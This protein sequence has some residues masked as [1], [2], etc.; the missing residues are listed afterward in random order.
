MPPILR[1]LADADLDLGPFG[2]LG[3]TP[4]QCEEDAIGAALGRQLARVAR[5]PHGGAIEADEVRLA[6]H[7]AAAQLRDPAVRQELIEDWSNVRARRTQSQATTALRAN[8][9]PPAAPARPPTPA[10]G[11]VPLSAFEHTALWVIAHSGGWNAESKR[12]LWALAHASSIAPVELPGIIARVAQRAAG[13]YSPRGSAGD[14]QSSRPARAKT[15]R[16]LPR[17]IPLPK[18]ESPLRK[19]GPLI[20]VGVLTLSSII[21]VRVIAVLR[22]RELSARTIA[23]ESLAIPPTATPPLPAPIPETPPEDTLATS[24]PAPWPSLPTPLPPPPSQ[25]RAAPE[26]APV[27]TV[28]ELPPVAPAELAPWLQLA[29]RVLSSTAMRPS[30]EE[31]LSKAVRLALVN[32]AAEQYAAGDQSGADETR[33]EADLLSPY[34]GRAAVS[35]ADLEAQLFRM[36]APATSDDGRVALQFQ[37]ARRQPGSSLEALNRLRF[38]QT[39]LGPA[40]CDVVAEVAFYAPTLELRA[41]ARRFV[42]D[43]SANPFMVYGLLEAAPRAPKNQASTEIIERITLRSLP[44]PT[45]PDWPRAARAALVARLFEMLSPD[46]TGIVDDLAAT[47]SGAYARSASASGQGADA[48]SGDAPPIEPDGGAFPAAGESLGAL[49]PDLP[50]DAEAPRRLWE[51]WNARADP[52]RASADGAAQAQDIVRR[53]AARLALADGVIQQF[54]A[55]QASIVEMAAFVVARERPTRAAE[56][57]SIVQALRQ[58]RRQAQHIFEQVEANERALTR[59]WMIRVGAAPTGN[60][61]SP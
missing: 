20:L 26:P 46:R 7:V 50:P 21:M 25:S 45:D 16:A 22:S 12:R 56:V 4:E 59:L 18:V 54:A 37:L 5:H 15:A 43:Q 44:R 19:W 9:A 10:R 61:G 6:L 55:E 53:R 57:G 39:P 38:R 24:E 29:E 1:F 23:M 42:D 28:P 40:D 31:R 30:I 49:S 51:I 27:S 11:R 36:T 3:L 58:E 2:L 32:C 17:A 35:A 60:R 13:G 34:S 8:S 52:F 41:L 33:H 47:L 14:S 48:Q